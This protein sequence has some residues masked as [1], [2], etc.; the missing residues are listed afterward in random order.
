MVACPFEMPAY[1]YQNAMTPQVRKCNLCAHL[2]PN[3][4]EAP[5]CVKMCPEETLTYGKRSELLELAHEKI[6]RNPDLYVDHVYGEHEAGG[7]SW[8][9]LSSVPFEEVGFWEVDE[10]APP[11]LTEKIQHGVFKHFGPPVM[12]YGIL[13]A[14]MHV[15]RQ[16][17]KRMEAA[18][19]DEEHGVLSIAGEEDEER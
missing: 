17:K 16:G 18:A 2:V 1:D 10:A 19:S 4:Q 5:T 14:I 15:T 8:L 12:L 6:R 3:Q 9:F 7:T 13:G 11:R